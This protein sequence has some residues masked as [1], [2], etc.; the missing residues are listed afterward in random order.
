MKYFEISLRIDGL[1]KTQFNV[2]HRD[3]ESAAMTAAR[4]LFGRSRVSSVQNNNGSNLWQAYKGVKTG[5]ATSVGNYF[6]V[7]EI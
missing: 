6:M 3:L 5:G 7:R 2:R 4:K 1:W